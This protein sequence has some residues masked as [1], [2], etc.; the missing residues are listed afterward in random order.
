MKAQEAGNYGCPLSMSNR[1]FDPCQGPKCAAWRWLEPKFGPVENRRGYCGMAGEP[2]Y[3]LN[4]E[5]EKQG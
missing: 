3:P 4:P 5:N 1:H 2:K